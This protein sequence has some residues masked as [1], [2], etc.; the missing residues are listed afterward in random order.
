[1]EITDIRLRRIAVEGKVKAV[2]SITFDDQF[3]VHDLRVVEGVNGLFLSMPSRKTPDGEFRDICH[4]ITAE[5]RAM[6]QEA[7]LKVFDETAQA[8]TA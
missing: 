5:C 1:M 3:V 6:I 2:A 7:V 8:K 4:P